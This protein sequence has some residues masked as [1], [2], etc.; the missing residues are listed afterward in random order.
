MLDLAGKLA[1]VVGAGP[2]G[3][4]KVRSLVECGARVRLVADDISAAASQRAD[5]SAANVET[6][7]G[8]YDSAHLRGASLVFACT[9]DRALNSRI[10]ADARAVG[11]LVNAADQ[12]E[13][14]DFFMPAVA[15]DGPITVAVGTGGNC[16]ALAGWLRNRIQSAMPEKLVPFAQLLSQL[17]QELKSSLP[18]IDARGD[19][20][21]QLMRQDAYDAYLAG[22]EAAVRKMLVDMLRG[23]DTEFGI[24]VSE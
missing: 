7:A 19:A 11:A 22:G 16:P 1:V 20:I 3:M 18:S 4:R 24:R 15:Q 23:R 8:K 21:R 17:R 12:V 6:I 13:D 14:C 5:V 2:V 10:A 9:D